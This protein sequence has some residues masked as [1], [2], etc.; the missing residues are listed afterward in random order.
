MKE[1]FC[2]KVQYVFKFIEVVWGKEK[3]GLIDALQKLVLNLSQDLRNR[4]YIWGYVSTAIRHNASVAAFSFRLKRLLS[5]QY[6]FS[7]LKIW[8]E[9]PHRFCNYSN[10]AN[11]E[12]INDI[13]F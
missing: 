4:S 5:T 3:L 12:L 7:G 8:F 11:V 6:W 10:K 1:I 13:Y 9:P 2:R